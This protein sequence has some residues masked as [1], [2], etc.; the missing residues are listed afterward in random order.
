MAGDGRRFIE[1]GFTLPKPL[2][3]AAGVPMVVRAVRDLPHADRIVF[4]VRASHIEEHGLDRV[5][6]RYFPQCRIV[7][8]ATL[9]AGQACTV[10]LAADEL[11]PDCPV[12]VAACDNTHLYDPQRLAAKLADPQIECLIWTYLGEPRV[13]VNPRQYGWVRVENERVVAVSCK[14][15]VSDNSLHDHVVSGCFI[16]RSA[17]RMMAAIDRMVERDVRI[18]NEFYLDVVP[19]LLIEEGARVEIFPVDKYVGWGTPA[20]LADFHRWER[21]FAHLQ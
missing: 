21:Y 15:P 11:E 8:V 3:P 6:R 7:P 12:I 5:L 9:T 2:I 19:N 1:A 4:L 18:N 20:D 10:R 17:R 16:F 13:L 14:T